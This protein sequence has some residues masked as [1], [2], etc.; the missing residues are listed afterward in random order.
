M[1]ST[2]PNAWRSSTE[3]KAHKT[4]LKFKSAGNTRDPVVAAG[5][6]D[7]VQ[8]PN[9]EYFADAPGFYGTALHELIHWT[10]GEKRLNRPK[11]M[12]SKSFGDDSYAAEEMR[13][14]IGS[15]IIAAEQGILHDPSH[16]TQRMSN[17]GLK[18]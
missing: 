15:M 7:H 4:G 1:K 3:D 2:R 10:G 18:H 12:Q 13:A 11:L 9:R 14:E 8:L 16:N 5:G 6:T 17:P